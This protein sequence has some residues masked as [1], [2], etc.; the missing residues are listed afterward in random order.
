M[1]DFVDPA[2]PT[3]LQQITTEELALDQE[4]DLELTDPVEIQR[5]LA[6][7]PKLIQKCEQ[8]V[9][10]AQQELE[11]RIDILDVAKA[12]AQL[13]AGENDA[14]TAAPDRAAWARTQPDVINAHLWV[15]QR[16]ADVKIAELTFKKYERYDTNVRKAANIFETLQ[17]AELSRMKHQA[18][19]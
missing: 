3:P 13:R 6:L 7:C 1:S 5:L 19:Q 15:I 17:N 14:L 16:R 11:Q 9:Q 18:R 8:K 12:K 10:E 4:A 2:Q